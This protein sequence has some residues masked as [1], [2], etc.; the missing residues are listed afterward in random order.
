[1]CRKEKTG[2]PSGISQTNFRLVVPLYYCAE[3]S[4][5][6]AAVATQWVQKPDKLSPVGLL[7]AYS[8]IADLGLQLNLCPL[9]SSL[10]H[11]YA[12]KANPWLT[13][14]P[15]GYQGFCIQLLLY[16][17]FI[18]SYSR[19]VYRQFCYSFL[20]IASQ[21]RPLCDDHAL[22]HESSSHCRYRFPRDTQNYILCT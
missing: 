18:I 8:I 4:K 14:R 3:N 10:Y 13:N 6:I 20:Q 5:P 2:S 19:Y 15:E 17:I 22:G 12:E 9:T 21:I 16:R 7:F 11:Y 1:M